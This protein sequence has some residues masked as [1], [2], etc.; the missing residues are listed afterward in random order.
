MTAVYACVCKHKQAEHQGGTYWCRTPECECKRF[1]PDFQQAA[2]VMPGGES[3]S[4]L[5]RQTQTALAASQADLTRVEQERDEAR[6]LIDQVRDRAAR[7]GDIALER[8]RERNEAWRERDL[9]RAELASA[10]AELEQL[11]ARHG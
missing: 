4:A 1:T 9:A 10:L 11:R 3:T 7:L 6:D 5:L 2:P 8:R